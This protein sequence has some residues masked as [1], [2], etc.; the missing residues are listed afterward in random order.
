MKILFI[1]TWL[2]IFSLICIEPVP[3]I[4]IIDGTCVQQ[5]IKEGGDYSTCKDVCTECTY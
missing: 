4:C 2:I 5:C 3:A 1:L